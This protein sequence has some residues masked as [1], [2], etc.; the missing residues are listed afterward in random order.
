MSLTRAE[1]YGFD[2]QQLARASP[3][4][5]KRKYLDQGRAGKYIFLYHACAANAPVHVFALFIPGEAAKL[6]L[7]DP[8]TRRQPIPRLSE[9]YADLL[10]K[11]E[12]TVGASHSYVYPDRLAFTSTYHGNDTAAL[13][14]ISREL[15]LVENKSYV[16]VISSSKEQSF[17]DLRA[18]KLAHRSPMSSQIRPEPAQAPGAA[19]LSALVLP[20]RP[21]SQSHALWLVLVRARHAP[22]R[23]QGSSPL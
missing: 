22:P 7:V 2:L 16:V 19:H 11:H 14:A 6:H 23:H 4:S 21:L 8:A 17:F 3:S 20:S 1:T 12:Q 13:K 10:G 15:G 18:P 9:L 5:A